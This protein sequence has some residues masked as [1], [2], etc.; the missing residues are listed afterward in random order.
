MGALKTM[1]ME[2]FA[3]LERWRVIPSEVYL[4]NTLSNAPQNGVD[5]ATDTCPHLR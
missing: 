2:A 3:V 4:E 5:P 1:F